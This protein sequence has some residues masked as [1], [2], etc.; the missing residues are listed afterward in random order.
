MKTLLEYSDLQT[1][2]R[3][4][5]AWV[6]GAPWRALGFHPGVFECPGHWS[7]WTGFK[8]CFI[9]DCPKRGFSGL[10]PTS[11]LKARVGAGDL[12]ANGN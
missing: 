4:R 1:R 8:S 7:V 9:K 12:S 10:G 11:G 5:K 6:S 3:G 2:L